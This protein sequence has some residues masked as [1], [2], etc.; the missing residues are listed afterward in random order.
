MPTTVLAST[1]IAPTQ[2]L[3]SEGQTYS[4][5]RFGTGSAPPLLCLQHFTGE[6]QAQARVRVAMSHGF[7]TRDGGADGLAQGRGLFIC[8]ERIPLHAFGPGLS[9][10]AS[11]LRYLSAAA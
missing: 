1:V 3:E 10:F 6:P 4:H 2:F 8:S 7:Q 5:R 11:Q 9:G